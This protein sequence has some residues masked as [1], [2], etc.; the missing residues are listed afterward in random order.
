MTGLKE[1]IVEQAYE[2][3]AAEYCQLDDVLFEVAKEA[4]VAGAKAVTE[5]IKELIWTE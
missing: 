1:K 2:W 3:A 5:I 4:F